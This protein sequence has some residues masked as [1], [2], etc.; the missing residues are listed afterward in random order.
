MGKDTSKKHL[1]MV[2][3]LTHLLEGVKNHCSDENFPGTVN[4][5]IITEMKDTLIN[6]RTNYEQLELKT[7][8]AYEQYDQKLNYADAEYR[9]YKSALQGRYSKTNSVLNEFGIKPQEPRKLRP[10]KQK[11]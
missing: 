3:D 1:D 11:P 2:N 6:L 8:Q 10:P 4:Q 7:R 9:K 5:G